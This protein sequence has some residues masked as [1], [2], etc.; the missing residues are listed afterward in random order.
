MSVHSV[1]IIGGGV[2]GLVCAQTLKSLGQA[3]GR[4]FGIT[5]LESGP[6]LGGQV[7]TNE[8]SLPAHT[9]P[10]IFEEGAEG[11]VARS[12]VFP[13]VSKLAGLA[14]TDLVSQLRVSDCELQPSQGD[15]AWDIVE[16]EPGVAAEKLGFQVP[17]E[18]R[19]R[20]IRS[21]RR[22]MSQFVNAIGSGVDVQL[23]A[24]VGAVSSR[25]PGFEV[26]FVEQD[27]ERILQ[28]DSVVVATPHSVISRIVHPLGISWTGPDLHHY[29]HVSVH[30]LFD[31][32]PDTRA[33]RS[34]TV[35]AKFQARFEG[36]RACSLVNEKFPLRCP[37]S[38]L[39]SRFYYRPT[40]TE[41]LDDKKKW[42]GFAREAF[43][44]IFQVNKPPSWSWVS[45]WVKTLPV[46]TD[47][48]LRLCGG[49]KKSAADRFNGRLAFAG[50]E[51]SGAGL[52]AAANSGR[53]AG[54]QI[55][56]AS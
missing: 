32:C 26:R 43:E 20:G 13:A 27:C 30:L 45:P 38:H 36:L 46:F 33:L 22:G 5:V 14:E 18:D 16:L 35:P 17:K 7:K 34:F 1:C 42:V 39:L 19:G 37:D 49:F 8:I 21:F 53:E 31:R 11:F 54:I 4:R 23:G 51:V 29:S 47:E 44:E 48:H 9:T 40:N 25:G 52:E 3:H 6:R 2:A 12:T 55:F 10:I 24:A 50:S 28:V 41:L 15:T 56:N